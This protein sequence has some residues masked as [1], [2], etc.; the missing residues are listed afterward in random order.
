MKVKVPFLSLADVNAPIA[1]ELA[2]A[3]RRVIEGG[4]YVLGREVAAFEQ[5]FAAHVGTRHVIGV[6]NGL[7]ALTLILR[8][9]KQQGRLKDGDGVIVPANTFIATLLAVGVD[10]ARRGQLQYLCGGRLPG[11]RRP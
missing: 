10:R 5:E 4:W 7:D 9:W 11:A 2:A 8:A 1:D 6:A 3:A